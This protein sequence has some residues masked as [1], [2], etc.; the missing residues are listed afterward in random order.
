MTLASLQHAFAATLR[1]NPQPLSVKSDKIA[2]EKR[3]QVYRNHYVVTLTETLKCVYP[4]TCAL[5]GDAC[6]EAIARYHA[7]EHPPQTGV[8]EDYGAQFDTTLRA[9]PNIIEAVPSCADLARFEWTQVALTLAPA[10]P[11][12]EGNALAALSL[13]NKRK[14]VCHSILRPLCLKA[15]TPLATCGKRSPPSISRAW[16]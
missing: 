3:L 16:Y 8:M 12:F 1:D 11:A 6:F 14:C 9:L 15:I 7:I 4:K 10:S 2:A 5:L 13:S